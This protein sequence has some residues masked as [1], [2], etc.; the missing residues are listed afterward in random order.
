MTKKSQG[1]MRVPCGIPVGTGVKS[2]TQSELSLTRWELPRKE[3][4]ILLLDCKGW[5]SASRDLQGKW[6]S[7]SLRVLP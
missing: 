7:Y 3:R 4:W 5:R 1:P 6:L 2:E